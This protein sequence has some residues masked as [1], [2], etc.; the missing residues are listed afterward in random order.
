MDHNLLITVHYMEG[1]NLFILRIK[2]LNKFDG[3]TILRWGTKSEDF[4]V[5]HQV[6]TTKKNNK[7]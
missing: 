1:E 2:K 3:V 4:Y 5:C 6:I 7:K